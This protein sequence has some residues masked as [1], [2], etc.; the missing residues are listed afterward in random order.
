MILHLRQDAAA[1]LALWGELGG[2]EVSPE[3]LADAVAPAFRGWAAPVLSGRGVLCLLQALLRGVAL[4]DAVPGADLRAALDAFPEVAR[5]VAAGR[6]VPGCADGRAFW[7]VTA[8]PEGRNPV[9]VDALADLWMRTAGSTTLSRAAAA[10]GAFHAEADA[11]LAALRAPDGRMTLSSPAFDAEVQ[12]W[13]APVLGA[14]TLTIRLRAVGSASWEYTF[15]ERTPAALLQLGQAVAVAPCLAEPR[16]WDRAGLTV[17]LRDGVPRLRDAGFAVRLPA[18]LEC[19]VPEL[20]EV[21]LGFEGDTLSVRRTV[22][23][24]GLE[25]SLAEA[26]ALV[27]AGDPLVCLGGR[28]VYLDLGALRNLLESVRPEPLTRRSALPLLLAG[29]LRVAPGA[30]DVQAFLR[31]MTQPPEGSV[32][33]LDVLRP[34]Q[35][36]G[37]C[38]LM[39]A[40]SHGLGVC[41]A[42]DMGLGKTLQTVA[43]LM[44]RPGPA[45]IVAPLTVLPVWEREFRRFA[46]GLRVYRHDGPG[47]LTGTPF[48]VRS[49]SVDVILT[50]YGY[51]WR[52]YATLRRVRWAT[53]VLDE[54]QQIKNPASRQSQAARSLTASCRLALTGT[55]IE[56]SLDD[57]WSILDFLNPGLYGTRQ[58]FRARYAAPR[59]LR[60]MVSHFLL[61]RL[62]SDPAVAGELPPKIR[63]DLFAPLTA[64]QAAAYDAALAEYAQGAEAQPAGGRAGAVLAL[65]TRLRQ[66][67]DHPALPGG[68]GELNVSDSG[69]LL[70]LLPLLDEISAAGESVLIF[71]QFV[72]MGAALQA[73]LGERLGYRVPF[74]HGGLS[75]AERRAETEVFNA[76]AGPSVLILSLRAG[77]FGL[78]LTKANHVIHFDRW[79]NP[80]VEAQATDRA[81]RIGQ[82]RTV[83][84]HTLRCRG[85]LEDSIDTL[86][87]DKQLLA[88]TVVA[89]T[90]LARLAALPQAALLDLLKRDAAS[91]EP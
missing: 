55:P 69:K 28:W 41:L 87:R 42:D 14:N 78:T 27:D 52:D 9:L 26:E 90:P 34:Y 77:A 22:S 20:R 4:P 50:A 25:L 88:D 80:A 89:A 47:R 30:G 57:L 43:F 84:V 3:A 73:I 70:A 62:K 39:Q 75:P 81:H 21:A 59:S 85:T 83:V 51:L 37:V 46:P 33:L 86:L 15:G 17:F 38:W 16:P 72:R 63:Q 1:G 23:F 54:A 7:K 8:L 31:E 2:R 53:L 56:N 68:E 64:V 19:Q 12:A 40:A 10:R 67:C 74:L 35:A 79:W 71:T 24:A 18:E 6:V 60:R 13:A 11:W 5:L 45:L 91:A 61:R 29:A 36:Q 76:H 48:V 32:P 58:A 65:L 82:T 44:T 66:I 49:R